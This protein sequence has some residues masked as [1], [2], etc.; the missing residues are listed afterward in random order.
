MNYDNET[1][2]PSNSRPPEPP[3]LPELPEREG[4]AR[5]R[6]RRRQE[7]ARPSASLPRASLPRNLPSQLRPAGGF[8]LPTNVHL[9]KSR[10]PYYVAGGVV[11]AVILLAILGRLTGGS[12][13]VTTPPNGLWLGTEW[14]YGLD[15]N[16]KVTD[17]VSRLRD[18][19]IGTVYAWVSWLKG[20]DKNWGGRKDGS[21]QF[22]EV[23]DSVKTFV[24]D[25]KSQYPES[26]L[27]GWISV[28]VGDINNGLS[29]KDADTQ[30]RIVDFSKH[31][32]NDLGFD[33][34]SLNIEP[35]WNNDQDF[36]AL[37]KK[38][39][40][41]VGDKVFISVAVPPDW[42]PIG[43]GIPVPPLIVPGTVWDDKYKQS[44]GLVVDEMALMAYNSGLKNA[45]DYSSWMAYQ[46]K[47]YADAI[48]GLDSGAGP[49]VELMVGIPTYDAEPPG[50][51][52]LVENVPSAVQGIKLGLQQAGD[53]ARY[54]QGVALYADW[55]TDEPEW[56]QFM[57]TWVRR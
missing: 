50:H 20:D 13:R 26:H 45:A 10:T 33:G 8:R 2:Q 44:V 30:T 54:V 29:I 7:M 48:A 55:E 43:A 53:N 52:P 4:K 39:R 17:L 18:H 51:D 56:T 37:L 21:N 3:E 34:L 57:M 35:V 6:R 32:V 16:R 15:P 12:S 28:P 47:T 23:E 11:I 31:V 27:Y 42:S 36:L 5:E 14:T 19:Q 1:P 9:P 25:F 49:G 40:D 46:V 24:R 22:A 41:A 38:V